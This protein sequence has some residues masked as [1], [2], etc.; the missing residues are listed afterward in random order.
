VPFVQTLNKGDRHNCHVIGND[1]AILPPVRLSK[2]HSE[3]I[4]S[5][6]ECRLCST[7]GNA[8]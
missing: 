2:S 6:E 4:R 5:L 7:M 8:S 3:S 1:H